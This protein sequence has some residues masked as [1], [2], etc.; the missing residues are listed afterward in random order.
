MAL[1]YLTG[2][3][4]EFQIQIQIQ[5]V[6]G[7]FRSYFQRMFLYCSWGWV[8]RP[9]VEWYVNGPLQGVQPATVMAFCGDYC[10]EIFLLQFVRIAEKMSNVA[11]G[12]LSWWTHWLGSIF[13]TR[14]YRCA[15]GTVEKIRWEMLAT[16]VALHLTLVSHSVG[17]WVVVSKFNFSSHMDL[18]KFPSS[19]IQSRISAYDEKEEFVILYL[20][21]FWLAI[22]QNI[23][24]TFLHQNHFLW[25]LLKSFSQLCGPWPV[26]LLGVSLGE[27]L[28]EKGNCIRGDRMQIMAINEATKWDSWANLQPGHNDRGFNSSSPFR[29]LSFEPSDRLSL[30]KVGFHANP[31]HPPP[32]FAAPKDISDEQKSS[33][34]RRGT[35]FCSEMH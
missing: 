12:C 18:A 9:L 29:I 23:W 8:T 31:H 30:C 17:L 2:W 24:A 13:G 1:T 15:V 16:H 6:P 3:D 5:G 22:N 26:I 7:V 27:P 19:S 10:I 34:F 33:R 20:I 21:L 14:P 4:W 28:G 11:A 25:F 35:D 32:S